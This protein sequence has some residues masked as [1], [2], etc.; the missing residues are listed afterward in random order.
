MFHEF[1]TVARSQSAGESVMQ[2]RGWLAAHNCSCYG[3]GLLAAKIFRTDSRSRN[4]AL[5]EK[6]QAV[7]YSREKHQG[8]RL[9][10]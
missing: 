10:I 9:Y 8:H 5:F 2:M 1:P 4:G 3:Q 6:K 7:Y